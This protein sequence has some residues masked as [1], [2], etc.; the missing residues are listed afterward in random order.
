MQ[1]N[2]LRGRTYTFG[3]RM[4]LLI[5]RKKTKQHEI[6]AACDV[7]RATVC[8]WVN[9]EAVPTL[10]NLMKLAAVTGRSPGWFLNRTS[11]P[12]WDKEQRRRAA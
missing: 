6:A 2:S 3:E 8:H 4:R 11:F 12:A 5:E 1:G 10:Q 9:D 7:S